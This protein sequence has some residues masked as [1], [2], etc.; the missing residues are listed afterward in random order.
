MV[1]EHVELEPA[2]P[3]APLA[4]ALEAQGGALVVL[5]WTPGRPTITNVV[6]PDDDARQAACRRLIHDW[7]LG[8]SEPEVPHGSTWPLGH[9]RHRFDVRV[10]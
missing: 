10:G 3:V 8:A 7:Q 4:E 9:P 1:V 5:R 6:L 2:R